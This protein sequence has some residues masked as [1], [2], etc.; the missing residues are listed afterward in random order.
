MALL[1]TLPFFTHSQLLFPQTSSPLVVLARISHHN[2]QTALR[3]AA[4][5]LGSVPLF[6]VPVISSSSIQSQ[7][8]KLHCLYPHPS[9]PSITHH[10]AHSYPTPRLRSSRKIPPWH[11]LPYPGLQPAHPGPSPL[12]RCSPRPRRHRL[13]RIDLR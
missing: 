8:N 1:L 11:S 10:L 12:C 5:C 7:I 3:F 13:R 2:S 9:P 4:N 6:V